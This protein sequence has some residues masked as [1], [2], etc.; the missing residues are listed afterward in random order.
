MPVTTDDI[1]TARPDQLINAEL[2]A[3]TRTPVYEYADG[4][5]AY[6]V[7]RGEYIGTVYSWLTKAGI[8]WLMVTNPNGE[9]VW[10]R[11]SQAP[12]APGTVDPAYW[13][14]QQWLDDMESDPLNQLFNPFA[15]FGTGPLGNLWATAKTLL[16][17]FLL[18]QAAPVLINTGQRIFSS[19]KD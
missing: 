4:P 18:L 11:Q 7:P 17:V 12:I 19:I 2:H 1:A 5:Q 13:D 14:Y 15:G 3:A 16:L 6:V 10:I 9:Y 8:N